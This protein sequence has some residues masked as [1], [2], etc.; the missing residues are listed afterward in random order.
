MDSTPVSRENKKGAKSKGFRAPP[1]LPGS[2]GSKFS[3][4]RKGKA[5]ADFRGDKTVGEL[6]KLRAGDEVT[7]I[8]PDDGGWTLVRTSRGSE[9]RAPTNYIQWK[10]KGSRPP[11][12]DS[13]Y[14]DGSNSDD[15]FSSD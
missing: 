14:Q 11:F 6:S 10:A 3:P 9:G 1:P 12:P 2:A 4:E 8:K 15:S 13:E 7:E 5:V